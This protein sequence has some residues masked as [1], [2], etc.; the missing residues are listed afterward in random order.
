[1]EILQFI[2]KKQFWAVIALLLVANSFLFVYDIWQER[3]IGI[4]SDRQIT[5]Q[6]YQTIVENREKI[7]QQA[8]AFQVFADENSFAGKNRIK[9]QKDYKNSSK[10]QVEEGNN[11]VITAVVS[12]H[13]TSWF[14]L[15]FVCYLVFQFHREREGAMWYVMHSL[16]KGRGRL[17]AKRCGILV[18]LTTFFGLFLYISSFLLSS[19]LLGGNVGW[20]RGIQ[21]IEA[22]VSIPQAFS[23]WQFSFLFI[24]IHILGC[25]CVGFCL[26]F[27]F[28][29][30]KEKL[31]AFIWIA[32]I[33]IVEY[34]LTLLPI[35]SNLVLVKICNL[36]SF[37]NMTEYLSAYRNIPIPTGRLMEM[38][39]LS[40]I[41][42]V[43]TGSLFFIGTFYANH[44]IMPNRKESTIHRFFVKKLDYLRRML[45]VLPNIGLELYKQVI[46]QRKW[47][48][49]FLLCVICFYK[50]TS[51]LYF[52]SPKE[53]F[54]NEFYTNF[55]GTVENKKVDA[56][57]EDLDREI[58]EAKKE[59]Q[60][61]KRELKN[62][63]ITATEYEERMHAIST[64]DSKIE[65][66]EYIYKERTRLKNLQ[67]STGIEMEY[68]NPRT[69]DPIC[70]PDF[71]KKENKTALFIMFILLLLLF[72]IGSYE[73]KVG[74]NPI[75]CSTSRG[76]G[77]LFQ[78]KVMVVIFYG[79]F[80]G[81]LVYGSNIW[82][83]IRSYGRFTGLNAPIQS[84]AYLDKV[85]LHCP[86]W[87]YLVGVYLLRLFVIILF[88]LLVY[89]IS[90]LLSPLST[91][92]LVFCIGIIPSLLY[93]LGIEQAGV[94]S[95]SKILAFLHYPGEKM[96]TYVFYMGV[97]VL[98]TI[99]SLL[100]GKKTCFMQNLSIFMNWV[101][102][103][104]NGRKRNGIRM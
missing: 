50:E 90:C 56:Y 2:K 83:I 51:G 46:G 85:T 12:N 94:I 52:A 74:M 34:L 98:G 86:I 60:I 31:V 100:I 5:K 30:C 54:L 77:M 48:I 10:I 75:L 93:Y 1:M 84:L 43:I 71:W 67:N 22:F 55:S 104:K 95:F 62:G 47:I 13:K 88:S 103:I 102:Q 63:S 96:K 65:G 61:I 91:F 64:I 82:N 18:I 11:R 37:V 17:G 66:Y 49:L 38:F 21:S 6:E 3:D 7:H 23:I 36:F 45:L 53:A 76:C 72:D 92:V 14:L 70:H 87:L 40:V 58:V 81:V 20:N 42:C 41:T 27:I 69:Y 79:I 68:V 57:L 4:L 73:K 35:Q 32:V 39:P 99:G 24:F 19:F 97:L 8:A 9:E 80:T 15:F 33:G 89:G 44:K 101:S 59:Q 29:C 25:C 16:P 26:F 28:S 78:K